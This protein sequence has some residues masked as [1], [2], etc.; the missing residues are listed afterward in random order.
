MAYADKPAPF[1]KLE[2]NIWFFFVS[3]IALVWL[4]P[5]LKNT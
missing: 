5:L 1:D 4:S 2:S 3:E